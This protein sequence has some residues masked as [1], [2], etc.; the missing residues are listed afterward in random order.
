[1]IALTCVAM[2]QGATTVHPEGKKLHE[3]ADYVLDNQGVPGDASTPVAEGVMAGPT[4]TLIGTTLLNLLMLEV[5]AWLQ[6]GGHPLP[7]LRSQN[8]PGAIESNREL[9]RQYKGRL[10]R[11]LA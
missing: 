2:A 7:I 1:V 6:A 5:I 9:A 11:Q 4:S 8:L 10:S 3:I